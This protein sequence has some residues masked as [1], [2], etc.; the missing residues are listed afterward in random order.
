MSLINDQAAGEPDLLE[1]TN[2]PSY[3]LVISTQEDKI[4]AATGAWSGRYPDRQAVELVA[5]KLK[6]IADELL[7]DLPY[8]KPHIHRTSQET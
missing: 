3:R 6:Q 1:R 2:H 8:V 4:F 5:A 7:S